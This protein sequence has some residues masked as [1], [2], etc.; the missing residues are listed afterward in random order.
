VE[1]A[2]NYYRKVAQIDYNY[3]DA[4]KRVDALREQ[5]RGGAKKDED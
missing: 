4:R 1:E 3:R 2:L 5:Q